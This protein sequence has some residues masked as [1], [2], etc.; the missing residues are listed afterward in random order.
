MTTT[1]AP[2]QSRQDPCKIQQ[3]K[4]SMAH[5]KALVEELTSRLTSAQHEYDDLHR[6]WLQYHASIAPIRQ[7]PSEVLLMIFKM[8][9]VE[10]PRVIRRLLL[11]CKHWYQVVSTSSQLW[12]HIRVEFTD[13]WDVESISKKTNRYI[14]TCLQRSGSTLLEVDLDFRH[15]LSVPDQITGSIFNTLRLFVSS[16][17]EDDLSYWVRNLD[18]RTLDDRHT[19]SRSHLDYAV[20]VIAKLAGKGGSVMKRWK[21][22]DLQLPEDESDLA[23]ELWDE[24]IYPTPNLTQMVVGGA[25]RHHL[26]HHWD[27]ATNAFPDLSSLKHLDMHDVPDW[28]CFTIHGSSL[29]SLILR[30]SVENW[31]AASLAYFTNLQTLELI[32]GYREFRRTPSAPCILNLPELRQ[33]TLRG[34]FLFA[35]M[36]EFVAPQLHMFEI[37]QLDPSSF[38]GLP[39]AQPLCISWK[40]DP[41][42]GGVGT[43]QVLQGELEQI[44]IAHRTTKH[45]ICPKILRDFVIETIQ[46]LKTSGTL[47]SALRTVE[48][49]G[50][51][52]DANATDIWPVS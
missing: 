30:R 40:P 7:C 21:R 48:F 43:S 39:K 50:D 20:E 2:Q 15:L 19:M 45:L 34:H 26:P 22:L 33:L 47:S 5:A 29:Q 31:T 16:E 4:H 46:R 44:L 41:Y 13:D 32:G 35:S 51:D 3:L 10:N 28:Q 12:T 36:I 42:W 1:E 17:G 18:T 37:I 24:F 14:D 6:E 38:P 11:V 49:K 8:Y 23:E 25:S 9:L 27:T 52:G